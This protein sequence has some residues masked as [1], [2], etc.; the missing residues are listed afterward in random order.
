MTDI[1]FDIFDLKEALKDDI[2]YIDDKFNFAI[3]SVVFDNRDIKG[4]SLFIAKKGEKTDGH[5]FIKNTLDSTEAVILAQYL[6]DGIIQ[7][8]RIILVKDTLKAFENLA[9]FSRNRLKGKVVGITGS[10]G[11]TTTKDMF[12][13]C[14]SKFGKSFCNKKS[15]NN[16]T[17]VLTTLTNTPKDVDFVIY[18]MGINQFGEMDILR[19]LVRP[20]IA[21]ITNIAESHLEYFKTIENVA[22]EKSK[23]FDK[24]TECVI[25]N[26]DI[27]TYDIIMQNAKNNNIKNIL[28][29]GTN[30]LSDIKLSNYE[31][32]NGKAVIDY[33]IDKKSFKCFMDNLDYNIAF[34]FLPILAVANYLNLDIDKIISCVEN[35]NTTKGRNN[36]EYIT[37][38]HN[39]ENINI[40]V[41]NGSYNAINPQTF[42][43]GLK[44]MN[45]IYSQGNYKRKVCIWGDMLE[46]G[47]KFEEFHLSLK[48]PILDSKIDILLTIGDGMKL[49]SD[50]IKKEIEVIHY[51]TIDDLLMNYK[52][53]LV[54]KDLVFIKSSNGM[55]T[56]KIID[57]LYK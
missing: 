10:F 24:N 38:E 57:D 52:N 13:H 19:N 56:Y 41:I 1:L 21:I 16:Y 46:V 33:I 39:N 30:E 42:I 9:I 34:N 45:N 53:F 15:F 26:S 2:I 49:L 4:Q 50:S 35:V 54:N 18:E 22:I 44:L 31:I 28:T 40:T 47:E 20:E 14:F 29:F 48:R 32:D 7:N 17:G 51:N 27:S 5:N 43:T 11:K 23:I 12:F 6:P 25:L 8:S 37:Y 3:T 36:I 55:K